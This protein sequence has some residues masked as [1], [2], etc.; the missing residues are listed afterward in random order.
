M[1]CVVG[2]EDSSILRPERQRGSVTSV[3]LVLLALMIILAVVA[4]IAWLSLVKRPA[5]ASQQEQNEIFSRLTLGEQRVTNQLDTRFTDADGDLV[6][7]APKDAAQW[8]DPPTLYFSYVSVDDPEQFKEAFKDLMAHLSRATGKTVEYYASEGTM[9]QIRALRDGRLHVTGLNTGGV[10]IAVNAAGFV[11]VSL[12][13]GAND[14]GLYKMQII[15]RAASTIRRVE[16]LRGRELALTEASSNS[17]YKAPLVLLRDFG[18]QPGR[19]YGIR[20]SLGQDASIDGIASGA[21]EV[22]AVASDV[23]RRAVVAGRISESQFRVVHESKE[24]P[25]AALGFAHNLKPEVALKIRDALQ[26]FE[27]ANSSL[28]TYFSAAGQNRFVPASYK[29]DWELVR[30]IDDEIGYVHRIPEPATQPTA[31]N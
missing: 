4:G 18:L 31:G 26:S 7:D 27:W 25:S 24:F 28:A 1:G 8:I 14:G 22:A 23:L 29:K 11:P 3:L 12:L 5:E 17:G 13:A 15:V 21:Y 9:D 30:R 20:Y 6:A 19:D 16:D 2:D 10:P